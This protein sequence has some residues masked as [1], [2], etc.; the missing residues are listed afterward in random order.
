[1]SRHLPVPATLREVWLAA[2][3]AFIPMAAA[4]QAEPPSRAVSAPMTG[5]V[6]DANGVVMGPYLATSNL[7]RVLAVVAGRPVAIPLEP[8][9]KSNSLD[10]RAATNGTPVFFR[11]PH[12]RGTGWVSGS[13]QIPGTSPAAILPADNHGVLVYVTDGEKMKFETF[14]SYLITRG[15]R[16]NCVESTGADWMQRVA[17]VVDLNDLYAYPYH[18]Q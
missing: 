4:A 5:M 18:L 6:A 8:V 2:S 15:R 14:Q 16:T 13:A 1:M 11:E 12:C 7:P 17:P 10:L 9:L 3:L